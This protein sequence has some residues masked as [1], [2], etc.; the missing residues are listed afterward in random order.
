MSSPVSVMGAFGKNDNNK[1]MADC[2]T[3][4][5]TAP[6]IHH[7]NHQ[8]VL[9]D[10][11]ERIQQGDTASTAE[12]IYISGACG[13]GK[14]TLVQTVQQQSSKS[15]SSGLW[16]G[17][18]VCHSNR[19]TTPF[20]AVASAMGGIC[21]EHLGVAAAAASNKKQ[22]QRQKKQHQQKKQLQHS[23]TTTTLR[24]HIRE[25]CMAQ[26][27]M[28]ELEL[29]CR[30]IPVLKQVLLIK[31]Q[32]NK[33]EGPLFASSL[34]LLVHVICRFLSI[35]CTADHPVVLVLDDLHQADPE[36]RLLLQTLVQQTTLKHLLLIGIVQTSTS[37]SSESSG[38]EEIGWLEEITSSSSATTPEVMRI[39][40][41]E[42]G[43]MTK[44]QVQDVVSERLTLSSQLSR[45]EQ[46]DIDGLTTILYN[47]TAGNP[48]FVTQLLDML[49]HQGLIVRN[50]Q[51]GR[52]VWDCSAI[53]TTLQ[54]R[55]NQ[56]KT[57]QDVYAYKIQ[58][59][60][61]SVTEQWCLAIAAALVGHG[62]SSSSISFDILVL[63]QVVTTNDKVMK[64]LQKQLQQKR[65]TQAD[66]HD[67][68][69][70]SCCEKAVSVGVL[71]KTST[72][73]TASQ[74][75]HRY[76]FVNDRALQAA[77]SFLIKDSSIDGEEKEEMVLGTI[78]QALYQQFLA[79][80]APMSRMSLACFCHENSET[81][82]LTESNSSIRSFSNSSK[83]F[84][85][86]VECSEGSYGDDDSDLV[87]L[88]YN[89]VLFACVN[90]VLQCRSISTTH[91]GQPNLLS[92][93]T[94]GRLC[95]QAGQLACRQASL[96]S[97]AHY[98]D[99]GIKVFKPYLWKQQQQ[100]EQQ[101][102]QLSLDLVNLSA[103]VH[104]GMGNFDKVARRVASITSHVI[105]PED[106][107]A[108]IMLRLQMLPGRTSW[109]NIIQELMS[110]LEAAGAP[111]V[112]TMTTGKLAVVRQLVKN[113]SLIKGRSAQQLEKDLPIM[114]DPVQN[115]IA[116]LFALLGQAAYQKSMKD[117][118][119]VALGRFFQ[120]TLM[121]GFG[122]NGAKSV[123][124]YAV[125]NNL[126]QNHE[127]AYDF[128]RL[129]IRLLDR[130]ETA[131]S[132]VATV[133][134]TIYLGCNLVH[135]P[136]RDSFA[137]YER[138]FTVGR[139]CGDVVQAMNCLRAR[140]ALGQMLCMNMKDYYQE[141]LGGL[142]TLKEFN[143]EGY[144]SICLGHAQYAE[145]LL[146]RDVQEASD[147]IGSHLN[148]GILRTLLLE[149]G[150]E[151]D[152]KLHLLTYHYSRIQLLY[153]LNM[154]EK[155][156]MDREQYSSWFKYEKATIALKIFTYFI[157][158]L[159][160]LSLYKRDPKKKV[161][162]RNARHYIKLLQPLHQIGFPMIDHMMPLL[163]AEE[164]SATVGSSDVQAVVAEYMASINEAEKGGFLV[165]RAIAFERMG[166]M[167]LSRKDK[168]SAAR[169]LQ[170]AYQAYEDYGATAKLQ[171][172]KDT[173]RD[174][175]EFEPHDQLSEVMMKTQ[176]HPLDLV[177]AKGK[178]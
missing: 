61:S 164:M 159:T 35:F 27:T 38:I 47:H 26:F 149:D 11:L 45:A 49:L 39:Q 127:I 135:Q 52:Y 129:A 123:S 51:Q 131:S 177:S 90:L 133:C 113:R 155:A 115:H 70:E 18:G 111:N 169:A 165:S 128:G 173:Y 132:Q 7:Q 171:L 85:A 130:P 33:E 83:H 23:I 140:L 103:Q 94:I 136:L 163:K 172:L 24:A 124:C 48:L 9:Q 178:K 141:C 19:R 82:D 46:H 158:G 138:G 55:N 29:L 104:F 37:T 14:T 95:L 5:A 175:I 142:A 75:C 152:E 145:C 122:P 166:E 8:Q 12:A 170:S 106:G 32:K 25:Q 60:L 54:H 154:F 10:A 144:V 116:R 98:V 62:H 43:P 41:L 148:I 151:G 40:H 74:Y 89:E 21:Q 57:I 93:E 97:A 118:S 30:V 174:S 120:Q 91:G 31:Q 121:Y 53:T 101:Y 105:K 15:N 117:L 143:Q 150:N 92:P 44:Q 139:G 42:Y 137:G 77:Y 134:H 68:T 3:E 6:K 147:L 20:Q 4:T 108:A 63:K 69:V 64:L 78:G 110:Q 96:R 87:L 17:T 161:H 16:W 36:T 99:A 67:F 100:E 167:Y 119:V 59:T 88:D 65:K 73:S 79:P 125:L 126:L 162:L 107:F 109:D 114:T 156:D 1:T 13:T 58:S 176:V 153:I 50:L 72:T 81:A 34:Q 28:D 76:G 168:T 157:S 102:Y 86:P 80:S 160:C 66:L 84:D 56:N 146:G 22:K 112:P 71:E 2:K